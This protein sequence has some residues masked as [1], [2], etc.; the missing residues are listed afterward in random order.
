MQYPNRYFKS[1]EEEK[2]LFCSNT[3]EWA[4]RM[5]AAGY[6]DDFRYAMILQAEEGPISPTSGYKELVKLTYNGCSYVITSLWKSISDP[7]GHQTKIS[8]R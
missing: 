5:H 3:C 8:R 2:T 6:I 7:S 4:R 1:A